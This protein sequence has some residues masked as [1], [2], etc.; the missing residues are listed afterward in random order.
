[1]R[2]QYVNNAIMETLLAGSVTMKYTKQ[3]NGWYIFSDHGLVAY[4]LREKE[5]YFSLDKCYHSPQSFKFLKEKDTAIHRNHRLTPTMDVRVGKGGV[6]LTRLKAAGW[7]TFVDMDLLEAFD[8][9]K[10]YQAEKVG[11]I[12]V[13]E[14]PAGTPDEYIR[15]FVMP[16]RTYM[17]TAGHYND[18]KVEE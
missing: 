3:E 6:L 14:G 16:V 4:V 15:G 1:M 13:T 11:P 18:K 8:N 2:I 5:I 9:P 17:E 7:D 12:T 10:F